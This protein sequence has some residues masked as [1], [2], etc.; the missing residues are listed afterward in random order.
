MTM[1]ISPRVWFFASFVT[2]VPPAAAQV[3]PPI[4]SAGAALAVSSEPL[5]S[6]SQVRVLSNG[7][8]LVNDNTGRRVVMFDS[9]LKSPVVVV[10]STEATG[11][12]Y[13][14]RSD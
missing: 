12:G 4:Q 3:L 11:N 7:H 13:N 9:T 6:V 5:A 14:E 8:V 1:N 10:D 2:A